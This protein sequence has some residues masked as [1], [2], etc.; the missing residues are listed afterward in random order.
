MPRLLLIAADSRESHMANSDLLTVR[1][2]ADYRRCSLRTLDRERADG[3]GPPYVR[4]GSRI[5]Y[6][7]ADVDAFIARHLCGGDDRAA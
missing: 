3:S 2:C 4:I 1:E 6:R 7:R 5:Y